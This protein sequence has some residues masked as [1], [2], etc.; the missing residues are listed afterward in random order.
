MRLPEVPTRGADP[1]LHHTA[2]CWDLW[3]PHLGAEGRGKRAEKREKREERKW[4]PARFSAL[5]RCPVATS[6]KL[7]KSEKGPPKLPQARILSCLQCPV[8]T[9]MR[10]DTF[11][12][13]KNSKSITCLEK[14][15]NS[16]SIDGSSPC[17]LRV[18]RDCVVRIHRA[19]G[20]AMAL[21]EIG[22]DPTRPLRSIFGRR[23][24]WVAARREITGLHSQTGTRRPNI[25]R[26]EHA[27][28]TRP[29]ELV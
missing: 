9:L 17:I 29:G 16:R 26:I 28:G 23:G 13:T 4:P 22:G 1:L 19:S 14:F 5:L 6:K 20:I 2:P 11:S 27:L 7:W 8:T 12:T 21:R 18:E 15:A 24:P 10:A 3:W 25:E